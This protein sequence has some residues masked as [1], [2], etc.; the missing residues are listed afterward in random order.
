MLHQGQYI[1]VHYHHNA[2]YHKYDAIIAEIESVNKDIILKRNLIIVNDFVKEY[3]N[4]IKQR[5]KLPELFSDDML[6]KT[7][8]EKFELVFSISDA[9]ERKKLLLLGKKAIEEYAKKGLYEK[10]V[11]FANLHKRVPSILSDDL[12]EV[13]L[14]KLYQKEGAKL[15]QEQKK[16]IS[17]LQKKYQNNTVKFFVSKKGK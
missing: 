10:F 11:E 16:V 7:I 13:E 9:G 4:F 2:K 3:S 5:G 6:E 17:V 1:Y 15:L 12:E 8:A 14:A